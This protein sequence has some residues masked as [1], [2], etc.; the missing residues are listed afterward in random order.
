[1]DRIVVRTN[2]AMS[3]VMGWAKNLGDDTELRLMFPEGEIEF[4]EELSLLKFREDGDQVCFD[5][6]TALAGKR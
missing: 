5:M 3:K 2:A 6:N 1:M 4:Q